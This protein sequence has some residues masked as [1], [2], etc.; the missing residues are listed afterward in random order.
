MAV[1]LFRCPI[2]QAPT[3]GGSVV[4]VSARYLGP[5]ATPTVD[6]LL[7]ARQQ[8]WTRPGLTPARQ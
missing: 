1:L 2:S 7:G 4:G 8:P 3:L 6:I 5:Y